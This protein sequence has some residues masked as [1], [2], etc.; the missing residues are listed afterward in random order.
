MALR[1]VY[2]VPMAALCG[3]LKRCLAHDEAPLFGV[4]PGSCMC[5]FLALC[6]CWGYCFAYFLG[7]VWGRGS[8]VVGLRVGDYGWLSPKFRQT[9]V[10]RSRHSHRSIGIN[11]SRTRRLPTVRNAILGGFARLS[12]ALNPKPEALSPMKHKNPV[13]VL[14]EDLLDP[15]GV[16]LGVSSGCCQHLWLQTLLRQVAV[17]A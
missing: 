11:V 6:G 13:H 5:R 14:R 9:L 16:F 4:Y 3:P 1:P 8:C 15:L 12:N 10:A 2:T 7:F 17:S